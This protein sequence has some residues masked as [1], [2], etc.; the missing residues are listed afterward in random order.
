LSFG[1]KKNELTIMEYL[2]IIIQDVPKVPPFL[3]GTS[4]RDVVE[5]WKNIFLNT[6]YLGNI[7]NLKYK[8]GTVVT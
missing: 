7:R 6:D 3:E 1:L 4:F 2:I 5:F 8:K